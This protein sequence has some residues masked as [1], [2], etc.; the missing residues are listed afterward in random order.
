MASEYLKWKYRDVKP[1][2]KRELTP[3][4]KRKNWWHYH[5]W[6]VALA[7]LLLAI[8]ADIGVSVYQSR[9]QVPDYQFA[10]VADY[11]LPQDTITALETRL[12]ALGEDC[13]G[14]GQVI[15]RVNSYVM[16]SEGDNAN[17]AAAGN[18]RLLG[19]IETCDSCF[20]LYDADETIHEN[21]G[22]LAREDGSLADEGADDWYSVRWGDCPALTALDLGSYTD[23]VLGETITGDSQTILAD[24]RLARRGFVEGRECAHP[25]QCE[26]LWQKMIQT[27]DGG[28]EHETE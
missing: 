21:Y 8:A 27:T 19:D 5:K 13:N 9:T 23:T 20:F 4:E 17:Y 1:E 14:D 7:A 16:N 6:H 10:W 22:I 18:V 3:A 11:A 12:A 25:Q 26:A 28:N 24:V 15:V 2:E